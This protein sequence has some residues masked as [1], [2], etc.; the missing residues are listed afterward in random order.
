MRKKPAGKGSE[1]EKESRQKAILDLWFVSML[2][3][4]VASKKSSTQS[5]LTS[6]Q[7]MTDVNGTAGDTPDPPQS[8]A[9]MKRSKIW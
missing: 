9:E 3:W 2:L 4:P 1:D 7:I 6:D 8:Q 5:S